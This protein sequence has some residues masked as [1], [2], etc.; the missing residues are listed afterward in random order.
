MVDYM[1]VEINLRI[2]LLT[3]LIC[4]VYKI[5]IYVIF[6]ISILLHEMFHAIFGI[7]LGLKI[8]KIKINPLGFNIEFMSFKEKYRIGKKIVIYLVGPLFNL[9]VALIFF[10]LNIN[11]DL[12][13]N[14]VYTNLV[15]GIFNMLPIL[16]LDGGKILKEICNVFLGFK[17]SNVYVLLLSKIILIIISVSYSILIFKVK[18]IFIFVVIVYLWYLYYLEEKKLSTV[19]KVYK[20]LER[21]EI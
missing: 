15:L 6:F 12:K 5:D 8:K 7:L 16:P 4:I 1:K 18:N 17:N 2:I 21:V 13:I 14:I 11:E 3:L 10:M 9:I 20:I 19:I